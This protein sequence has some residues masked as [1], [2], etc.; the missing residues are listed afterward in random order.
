[1][2][3]AALVTHFPI[4]PIYPYLPFTSSYHT[5]LHRYR[6]KT[7]W[8][9]K[10]MKQ[11][12][13]RINILGVKRELLHP[14]QE[15]AKHTVHRKN[16]PQI[17][18]RICIKYVTVCSRIGTTFLNTGIYLQQENVSYPLPQKQFAIFEDRDWYPNRLG[19]GLCSQKWWET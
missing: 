12:N 13:R 17:R 5:L 9:K 6:R 8:G 10:Y 15:G 14:K 16:S 7:A 11:S 4:P 18:H 2:V 1:M 3:E 19:L